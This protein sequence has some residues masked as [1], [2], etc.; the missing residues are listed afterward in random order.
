MTIRIGTRGSRLAMWQAHWV[1][2][3]L[4]DLHG[5]GAV[6][7]IVISTQGDRIQDLSL[8][9][10]GDKGFF[11]KEIEAALLNDEIDLAVHSAKDLPTL[12]PDGLCL[13]VFTKREDPADVLISR[14]GKLL[15]EL[16]DGSVVG[17]SSLRRQAQ[18]LHAF[19]KLKVEALRGNVDTRVKKLEDAQYDAIILAAAGVKR[20]GLESKITESLAFDI[21]LPAVGQGALALETRADDKATQGAIATLNDAPTHAAVIAERS[22]LRE[23]EGGCRAPIGGHGRIE[24][25]GLIL[26]AFVAAPDGSK[27]IRKQSRGPATDAEHIGAALAQDLK[28]NGATEILKALN[29][30]ERNPAHG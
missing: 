18:V 7:L 15:A 13:S 16:P 11:T 22:L 19:P 24:N 17:T 10:K 27:L 29:R 3:R 28:E 12:Q 20:L 14:D 9:E 23:L 2:D 8:F 4:I 1:R 5:E 6:E 25:E 30:D 21:M 26:E